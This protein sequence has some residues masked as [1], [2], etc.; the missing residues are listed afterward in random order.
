[1]SKLGIQ[2][3]WDSKE[4]LLYN[5]LVRPRAVMGINVLKV[6][7]WRQLAADNPGVLRIHRHHPNSNEVPCAAKWYEN[8][9][10][11][12]TDFVTFLRGHLSGCLNEIDLIAGDNEFILAPDFESDERIAKADRFMAAFVREAEAVLGKG[13]CVLNANV[14][15]WGPETVEYFPGTLTAL[16][17]QAMRGQLRSF[18]CSHEY[19]W[20]TLRDDEHWYTGKFTRMMEPI[21]ARYPDVRAMITEVGIDEAA[22]IFGEH[23]GWRKAHV[24]PG[25]CVDI[26]CGQQ[27]YEWYNDLLNATPYVEAALIFG[28]GMGDWRGMGFDIMNSPDDIAVLDRIKQYPVVSPEPPTPPEEPP[29]NGGEPMNV[30]VYDFDG[31][32]KDWA[33][34]VSVFGPNLK[35]LPVEEKFPLEVGDHIYKVDCI[36]AKRGY[37]T[38]L[39]QIK[40]L[41][42]TPVPGKRVIWGW[43]DAP[44]H[45]LENFGWNWTTT[46]VHDLTNETGDFGPPMGTGAYYHPDDPDDDVGPHWCWAYDLPSDKVEGI[47]MLSMTFHDHPDVG[48]REIIY[49]GGEP[50]ENGGSG[51]WKETSRTFTPGTG[52]EGSIIL[53]CGGGDLYNT[54]GSVRCGSWEIPDDVSPE[55]GG[56]FTFDTTYDE[57]ETRT[58]IAWVYRLPGMELVSDDISCDFGP[59]LRGIYNVYLT[60]ESVTP[61][62]PPP[63]NGELL[64]ELQAFRGDV[65]DRLGQIIELLKQAPIPPE[66][67]PPMP[68]ELFHGDFFSNIALAGTP[69]WSHDVEAIDFFWGEGS[70]SAAV[71]ADNFSARWTGK[72]TFPE[73]N[74]VFHTYT[75]DGVRLWVDNV[76][77]IDKWVD[78]SPRQW[79]SPSLPLAAGQHDLKM[80]YYEKG[81]GSTVKMWWNKT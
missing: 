21:L 11:A 58:Y 7:W 77:V 48:Y 32:E 12:A 66:L 31:V 17:A 25:T 30:K 44:A 3:Q 9:E 26:L 2:T 64:K 51:M 61:P 76:L 6:D 75:D 81:G 57:A 45:S 80:E 68:P 55:E 36:R 35:I 73:G 33:W 54:R 14:G 78:Q 71:P 52:N 74:Y 42:G 1:M 22:R 40:N 20:P 59:G 29:N 28:C 50:P 49:G 41:D 37:A 10:Q 53:H 72:K 43:P 27:G 18:F 70:P 39:I 65:M 38:C 67:P 15:H 24:D 56:I 60:W 79:D 46:G 34:L 4:A 16:Q 5:L 8:P 69:V 23:A 62:I 19:N 63:T 47:G 13:V